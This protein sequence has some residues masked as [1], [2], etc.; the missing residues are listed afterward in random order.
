MLLYAKSTSDIKTRDTSQCRCPA[1]NQLIGD[2]QHRDQLSLKSSPFL[3]SQGENLCLAPSSKPRCR[4]YWH[5]YQQLPLPL[6]LIKTKT[7]KKFLRLL[8]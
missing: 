7:S 5:F 8:F 2:F 4:L 6:H 3:E 1:F